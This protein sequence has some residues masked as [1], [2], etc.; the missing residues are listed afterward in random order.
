LFGGEEKLLKNKNQNNGGISNTRRGAFS[1][2][3]AKRVMCRA[4]DSL[5][6]NLDGTN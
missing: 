5:F 1:N 3:L 4:R 6:V 2:L